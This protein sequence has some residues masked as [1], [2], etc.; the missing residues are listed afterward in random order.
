MRRRLVAGVLPLALAVVPFSM[1]TAGC[2]CSA[3][4]SIAAAGSG[5][6][7]SGGGGGGGIQSC[8]PGASRSD[9][10]GRIAV[11]QA[12]P[13]RPVAWGVYPSD[14]VGAYQVTIDVDGQVYDKKSQTYPPHGSVTYDPNNRRYLPSG[15]VF[16]ITGSLTHPDGTEEGFYFQCTLA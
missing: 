6:G 1:A 7:C 4:A 11:Q 3:P 14:P 12:G 10:Y 2:G 13:Q 15:G 5:G 16:Q 8:S 9:E